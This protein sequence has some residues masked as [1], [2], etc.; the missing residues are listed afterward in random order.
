MTGLIDR[1]RQFVSYGVM[2]GGAAGTV[3]NEGLIRR[4]M[5]LL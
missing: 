4:P 3:V 5:A 2:V 1:G